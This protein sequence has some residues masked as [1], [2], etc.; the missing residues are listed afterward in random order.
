MYLSLLEEETRSR[1]ATS[2]RER[3]TRTLILSLCVV[4]ILLVA[5]LTERIEFIPTKSTLITQIPIGQAE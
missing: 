1:L 4:E 2:M 5:N 3:E